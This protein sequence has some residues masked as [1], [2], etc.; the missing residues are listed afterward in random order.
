MTDV[1]QIQVLLTSQRERFVARH[2]AEIA[3]GSIETS[4][5]SCEGYLL[6]YF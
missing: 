5:T 6:I 4:R 1:H 3:A 2:H